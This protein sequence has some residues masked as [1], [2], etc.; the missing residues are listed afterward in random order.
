MKT[1]AEDK[2]KIKARDRLKD[3]CQR[4][5][6]RDFD[7]DLNNN[8]R[9]KVFLK[10]YIEEIYNKKTFRIVSLDKF[11]KDFLMDILILSPF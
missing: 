1:H 7:H 4:K 3:Y 5:W 9:S 10:F 11:R 6:E 2:K 8:E